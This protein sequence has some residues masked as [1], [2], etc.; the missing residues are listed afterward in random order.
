MND[1]NEFLTC[2][3]E[4]CNKYFENPIKLPCENSIC[5]D[6]IDKMAEQD[7]QVFTCMFCKGEHD[8]HKDDMRLNQDILRVL[9]MNLHLSPKQLVLREL[10]NKVCFFVTYLDYKFYWGGIYRNQAFIRKIRFFT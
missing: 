10:V 3:Y 1:I 6:H 5:K 9:N 4:N 7:S 2:K 8:L